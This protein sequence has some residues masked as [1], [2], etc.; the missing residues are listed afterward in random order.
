[1]IV[2]TNIELTVL[3]S[4]VLAAL[5]VGSVHLRVNLWLYGATTILIA[6]AT[7]LT[8]YPNEEPSLLLIAL[9]IAGLKSIAIPLF[10]AWTMDR[11]HVHRDLGALV[12]PPIAM[13]SSILLLGLSFLL[14]QGLPTPSGT[15]AGWY[16]ASAGISLVLTGLLLMLTRRLAISQIIGFLVIE[17][18]IY[19]FALTQT[20]GM[21][22]IIEMGILL[23][24]LVGV[25]LAG[26]LT[27]K[28]QETFEHIDIAKLTDL[29][30]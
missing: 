28:I 30:D 11:I 7:G 23:D 17:N 27:F 5:M 19:V 16:G 8:A 24:V 22:L 15:G 21:P 4:A 3:M 10:L 25:M 9:L 18:G 2:L 13:H 6:I 1:M 26:L 20:R 14:T 29:K 12:A